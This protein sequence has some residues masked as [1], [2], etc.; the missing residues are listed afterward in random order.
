MPMEKSIKGEG[1][2]FVEEESNKKRRKEKKK[3]RKREREREERGG[4]GNRHSDGRNSSDQEV[5]SVYSMRATLQEVWI[6]PIFIYF[7]S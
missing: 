6:L 3:R 5:M 1:N 2:Q 4:K 7:P